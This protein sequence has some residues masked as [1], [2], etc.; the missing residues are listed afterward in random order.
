MPLRCHSV[1]VTALSLRFMELLSGILCTS[2][3]LHTVK[4]RLAAARLSVVEAV[5]AHIRFRDLRRPLLNGLDRLVET[6]TDISGV[7]PAHWNA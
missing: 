2:A 3:Q 1:A 6:T 7:S 5:D 4:I